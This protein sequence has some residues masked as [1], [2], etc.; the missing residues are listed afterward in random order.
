MDLKGSI[1]VEASIVV[2]IAVFVTFALIFTGAYM[3][4]Y[5]KTT[6]YCQEYIWEGRGRTVLF[7][8]NGSIDW[9]AWAKKGIIDITGDRESAVEEELL[10]ELNG[11]C[12]RLWFGNACAFEAEIKG[13]V[14]SISFHG[15][16]RFPVKLGLITDTPVPFDGVCDMKLLNSS[17]WIRLIQGVLRGFGG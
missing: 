7:Q 12:P 10:E 1:T 6:A 14:I 17:E 13:D 9:E 2:S 16:Y 8:K 15:E 5:C 3:E 4:D 11:N